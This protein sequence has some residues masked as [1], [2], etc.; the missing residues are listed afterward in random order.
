MPKTLS[1]DNGGFVDAE[2]LPAKNWARD[3][4]KSEECSV[5][6]TACPTCL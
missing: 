2:N 3:G 1:E 6:T 4:I 5:Q